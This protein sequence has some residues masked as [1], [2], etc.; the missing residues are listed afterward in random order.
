DEGDLA[1]SSVAS[2]EEFVVIG[3]PSGG[4]GEQGEVYVFQ[5]VTNAPAPVSAK[6]VAGLVAAKD[7]T[8]VATL[9]N[10]NGAAGLGDKWG[11]AV[12]ISP[13]GATIVIGAPGA[14]GGNGA[15]AMFSRP[16]ATWT[17]DS[18]PDASLVPA[19]GVGL[20]D[21]FGTAVAV[22]AGNM[23]AVGAPAA[24]SGGGVD[25]GA[26]HVFVGTTPVGPPLTPNPATADA[27]ANFGQSLAM[28]GGRL[29]VG[30]PNEGA[31]EN[32]AVRLYDVT[33]TSVSAPTTLAPTGGAGIGDKWGTS[34]AIDGTTVVGGAPGAN[35]GNGA[36]VVFQDTGSGMSQRG[37]L[38]GGDDAAGSGTGMSVA[39]AGDY[40]LLGA[41]L[42]SV[43]GNAGQGR[44]FVFLQPDGGWRDAEAVGSLA[45]A[46][47]E[48]GDGY[49]SAVALTRR[50]AIVGIP[51]RDL[52]A[53][54]DQGQADSF[55]VDRIFR[56]A[57]E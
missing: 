24:A 37:Q 36:G 18:T 5:R 27:N 25:A 10:P 32:G 6:S 42:A 21:K 55:V 34:V 12:A 35:G 31:G 47:G 57:F 49:G 53:D 28:S 15:A 3:A 22:G 54:N 56:A 16:G 26:A 43:D 13:D 33:A 39:V 40:I 30:A 51:N 46:D 41:P 29:V 8:P 20:G 1:G 52:G 50:G 45:G 14:G 17:N 9:S 2:S 23:I 7:L 11:G 19:G 48:A 4:E 44:A 38:N